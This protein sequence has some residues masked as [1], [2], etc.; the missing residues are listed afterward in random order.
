MLAAPDKPAYLG[1]RSLVLFPAQEFL[2]MASTFDPAPAARAIAEAYNSGTRL[3]EL[4]ESARPRT[5]DEGLAVQD[6]VAVDAGKAGGI[7]DTIAGWKLGFGSANGKKAAGLTRALPGR[8]FTSRLYKAGDNV[9]VPAGAEVLVEIEIAVRLARDIAPGDKIARP[10]DVVGEAYIASE[11]V[12]SRF[13]DRKTVGLPSF[14]ADSVGFHA[15]VVGARVATSAMAAI[16]RSVRVTAGGRHISS[17][18]TGGD[19]IDPMTCLGDLIAHA[20]VRGLTLHKGEIVTTGT[21]SKPFDIK[22]PVHLEAVADGA[23]LAFSLIPQ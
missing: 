22:A 12:V 15:L 14:A 23:S 7:K 18:Q 3:R 4:P 11:L 20:A 8:L 5:L 17:P 19:T 10:L 9:P 16:G 2:L 21:L 6:R 13:L 1:A